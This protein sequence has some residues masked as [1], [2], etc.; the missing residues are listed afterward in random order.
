MSIL[1]VEDDPD[2]AAQLCALLGQ[3]GYH[4][5]EVAGT[6][7]EAVHQLEPQPSGGV[8]DLIL[9]DLML[10][11]GNGLDLCRRLKHTRR[12]GQ[13]PIVVVS[14]I[15]DECTIEECLDAGACD[16]LHKPVRPRE[17]AARLR[18]ALRVKRAGEQHWSREHQLLGLAE[19]LRKN[20][21]ELARLSGTDPLTG[22]ANRRQFNVVYRSE[23]RR[24]SRAALP[25]ALVLFDVDDFHAYNERYGHVLG[26][27]CLVA[28]ATAIADCGQR[29]SDLFARYGGEEFVFVLPET[30]I[31]GA[32]IVAE[33]ARARV[34]AL[35]LPHDRARAALVV[36]ISAGYASM[37]PRPDLS[38]ETLLSEA[39]DALL[40][41]KHSGRNRSESAE[42]AAETPPEP[43]MVEVD[44]I[45]ARRIP[46][47][48]ANRR[49]DVRLVL[50]ALDHEGF[51]A[52]RRVGH[53]LKG[54]GASYGFQPITDIGRTIED[55]AAARDAEAIRHAVS[56]LSRYLDQVQVVPQPTSAGHG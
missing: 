30:D 24:A 34:Q 12:Y 23:W 3:E 29:P 37:V 35:A 46:T 28:V 33:R 26:D 39:D 53:N 49:N 36:T 41:A 32:R 55:S 14:S 19:R 51:D 17:L 48:L 45:I 25:L 10:P 4:H 18:A 6:M 56:D 20:N 54:S 22:V 31:E 40:R 9:V 8:P 43:I 44:P 15:D 52:I 42:S 2:A 11:D 5:V 27:Q 13:V 38:P 1:L 7:A 16:Y 47:F 21:E 50:E